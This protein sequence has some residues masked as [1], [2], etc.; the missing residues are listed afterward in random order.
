[1]GRERIARREAAS[2]PT[3]GRNTNAHSRDYRHTVRRL[4]GGDIHTLSYSHAISDAAIP[5]G[6]LLSNSISKLYALPY[7]HPISSLSNLSHVHPCTN[8]YIY[9]HAYLYRSTDA[10]FHSNP[11]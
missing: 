9:S 3:R 11:D 5:C 7:L 2:V 10:D 6:L 8:Q 4:H 1:V